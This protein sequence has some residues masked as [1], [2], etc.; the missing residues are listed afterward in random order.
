VRTLGLVLLVCAV[1]AC[2]QQL[3]SRWV[4]PATGMEF[5]LLPAG[6]FVAG[7][8][9]TE[10]GHQDDEVLYPVRIAK[11]LYMATHEVTQHAWAIVMTPGAVVDPAV[12]SLPVVNVTW[13]EV[14]QFLDRLNQGAPWRL[15]LP[16]ETEWEYACRAGT[17]TAYSTGPLLSTTDANYNGEFPLPGQPPGQNR[18]RVTPVA[19]F[20]PN[21]FG[22]FDMHGN[23]WE[24][25]NDGYDDTRKVI[26]G[27]SWRFDADSARCALRYHHRPGERGDSL[28]FRIVRD[29][30][31]EEADD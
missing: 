5:A 6:Q 29:L 27:G 20:P 3:P 13:D 8:P 9:T 15:R 30:I 23:V 7:S 14:R 31:R 24:W 28:G 26:R 18:G 12:A 19:S 1:S 11:P 25:T 17:T 2:S 22:L 10:A 4:E 21:A 16:S